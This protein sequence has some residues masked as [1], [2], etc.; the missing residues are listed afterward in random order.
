M[1]H[2]KWQLQQFARENGLPSKG[3]KA[4]IVK[5]IKRFLQEKQN[6]QD[7]SDKDEI[8]PG[9][10]ISQVSNR[11][12][13]S[14]AAKAAAKA[15][16]LAAAAARLE[17]MQAIEREE[18]AL[19]QKK[20]AL[21]LEAELAAAEAEA[22]AY[23]EVAG[24]RVSK[25]SNRSIK[26][27]EQTS[28]YKET[29]KNIVDSKSEDPTARYNPEVPE[30]YPAVLPRQTDNI[31]V[32][33]QQQQRMFD[34]MQL[35]AVELTEF[36]G[37]PL[38]YYLFIRQ[39]KNSVEYQTIPDGHKLARL[40]R[41]CTGKAR[42]V[43]ESCAVMEPSEGYTKAMKLLR[44]RFG[45]KYKLSEAW[46]AKVTNGPLI[47]SRDG[48][49]L[50]EFADDLT[51]CV[52][53]LRASGLLGEINTQG[54]LKKIVE[55]LPSYLRVRWLKEVQNVKRRYDRFPNV[56]DLSV[57]VSDAAAESN[58]PV[59]G[60]VVAGGGRI[61]NQKRPES[62]RNATTFS[63]AVKTDGK[64]NTSAKTID[65]GERQQRKPCWLCREDH[66]IFTC[67]DFKK[68]S[69]ED[70]RKFAAEKRLCFNCLNRGHTAEE[71]RIARVCDID[72]CGKKH[73]RF[74]HP[75]NKRPA[76][77]HEEEPQVVCSATGA[78]K[79]AVVL[80][81]L[82][83][84]VRR[85]G[86]DKWNTAYALLDTASTSTFCSETLRS[87]LHL[88]GH[89][90][91]VLLNTMSAQNVVTKVNT[92]Q[93]EVAY[94]DPEEGWATLTEVYSVAKLPIQNNA[95]VISK[96]V[97]GLHHFADLN[98]VYHGEP[99]DLLIGQDHSDLLVP[100]EVRKGLQPGSPYAVR[101]RLG[102]T[103]NGP[104]S[105]DTGQEVKVSVNFTD[106][107]LERKLERFWKV[108]A[109][110]LLRD[111]RVGLSM[112][113]KRVL[114]VYNKTITK[115]EKGHYELEI[116]FKSYPLN[117]PDNRVLAED[118]LSGLKKKLRRN[119]DLRFEYTKVINKLLDSGHAEP[120]KAE[121]EG[122]TW[123]IPHQAVINPKR[124]G[125][126]RVVFDCSARYQG[127]SLNDKVF[128]GPD[129]TSNLVGVLLRFREREI[130]FM[131]DIEAM[132][133]Q[134]FVPA[135]QRNALCFLWWPDGDLDKAPRTYR[136]TTHLFGGSWSPSAC[137]YAL[138]RIAM[139]Q[140]MQ[141]GPEVRD[142]I[143]RNFYVDDCLKSVD[144]EEQAVTVLSKLREAV[145]T[146]GFKLTKFVSNS[147]R[148]MK[149]VP[150]DLQATANMPFTLVNDDNLPDRALGLLWRAD[151][152][153]LA[154]DITIQE[155]IH[156]RRQLLSYIS[157]IYDPLGI[158]GPFVIPVKVVMQ[159]LTKK[160]VG[161]DEQ[162][163][164]SQRQAFLNWIA[165]LER[166]KH[167]CIPRCIQSYDL[168]S[169]RENQL[170]IFADAS[171]RA[172]GAVAYLRQKDEEGKVHTS[173]LVSKSRLAPVKTMS[174]PR[175]ELSA[176]VL[177]VRL[178]QMITTES[179]LHM[180]KSTFWTDSTIVLQ[181]IR[182]MDKRFQTFVANRLAIIQE[183]TNTEQWRHV[184]SKENPADDLSRGLSDHAERWMQG[185][186][187]LR[188][189]ETK[190]PQGWTCGPVKD[191]DP[192]VKKSDTAV[193]AVAAEEHEDVRAKLASRSSWT[194]T[195][196]SIGWI[197][198]S[199]EWLRNKAKGNATPMDMK[200]ITVRELKDAETAL[201]KYV[202]QQ[203]FGNEISALKNGKHLPKGSG[204]RRLCPIVGWD[205]LL[206]LGGRLGNSELTNEQKHP[207]ILPKCRE[208]ELIL[209]SIHEQMGHVGREHL[210]AL[211]RGRYW[212][213]G[214]RRIVRRMQE[215]CAK[216]KLYWARPMQ[217]RMAELPKDRV[218]PK[219]Y[220]FSHVGVDCFGPIL[221]KQGR[222][223]L[224]RYGCL[225]TC[226]NTRAVHIELLTSMDTDAFINGLRRFM[227]RRGKP[228][229]IRSDNGTNFVGAQRELKELS[230][231]RIGDYL[232]KNETEWVFSTPTAS[233]HGGVWE[234]MIK[235][236]KIVLYFITKEQVLTD[237]ALH[238]LLCEA[239]AIVN[240][241]PITSVSDDPKDDGPL[242]PNHLLMM[243]PGLEEPPG[244]FVMQDQYRKRWRQIQY[245]ADLFW[246]RWLKEYLPALQERSKWLHQTRNLKVGDVVLLVTDTHRGQWPLA[247]VVEVKTSADGMVRSV[248]VLA[249]GSTL[250]RPIN[251]VCL[252]EAVE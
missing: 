131:G 183:V 34:M 224:K 89:E 133:N 40:F 66:S 164:Q 130:A 197:L 55:R 73:T 163:P 45:D 167:F 172:Y 147:G 171:E 20:A 15:A 25:R 26:I 46:I 27:T 53:S 134:V 155:S 125:K 35:P 137:N 92:V 119:D 7:D 115:N 234:R 90:S 79:G 11:S 62:K 221:T 109:D 93:I 177:A 142:T 10:S 33:M 95:E 101:T 43:I 100:R 235:S 104:L 14:S 135:H 165:V 111:P 244:R 72:G 132:F 59:Y 24:S 215:R 158:L 174:I 57:F 237:E 67:T 31:D 204:I 39:F 148:V 122:E 227:S 3:N 37:N 2:S 149:S 16:Q 238:T 223:Q 152:D 74:L 251:K 116:P 222:S 218:S 94:E 121:A 161:W 210:L 8:G 138:R 195:K 36:D 97:R 21:Q 203:E 225:F 123:F 166:M 178:Y 65:K 181:Y 19:K 80:P 217:Q 86:N 108:E 249:N 1:K 49:K 13:T 112:N 68:K 245:L 228:E 96:A 247:R 78:G 232:R 42:K 91:T 82:P 47:G 162:L 240:S 6:R 136:M 98:L 212:I 213:L 219:T 233:H 151:T 106:L 17:D 159:D 153:T 81:I 231:Q 117:L 145:A 175:L 44:E 22:R 75:I 205:G 170:H 230:Q 180:S 143:L 186:G 208:A 128:G 114:D 102:W 60:T 110:E 124:P 63:T 118:R 168:K 209:Q 38:Q 126:V 5:R 129:L 85:N 156:T 69:V 189:S 216:C 88:K 198:R 196:L 179:T 176:A 77:I 226:L 157:S 184:P 127:T 28:N 18:F 105:N 146:G 9:D 194:R 150:L 140:E 30:F 229:L 48:E 169:K 76:N 200:P 12:S 83:V 242:T 220:P 239:E 58:D 192:E 23:S 113:D 201:L 71:C 248:K 64:E 52:Q 84:K 214:A 199:R 56:D 250:D 154:V 70:R 191:D 103:L 99:V 202:Q 185:P 187:F 246:R 141:F 206:R 160:A 32:V 120:Q 29:M 252:L 51:N 182:N 211:V 193:Y 190:W 207:I 236:V 243:R 144:T 139:D 241:R 188:E 107:S 50:Q 87:K 54:V 41:Y 61:D 173:L 4:D